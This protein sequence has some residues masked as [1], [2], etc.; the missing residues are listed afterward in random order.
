MPITSL[1]VT[2]AVLIRCPLRYVPLWLP[3]SAIWYPP[4]ATLRSSA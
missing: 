1:S 4:R 2:G 3:R